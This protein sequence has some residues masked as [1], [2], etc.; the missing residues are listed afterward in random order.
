ML[1]RLAKERGADYVVVGNVGRRGFAGRLTGSVP[2]G[3]K[4]HIP[5]AEVVIVDT[6]GGT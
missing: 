2:E 3:I 1:G 5:D 6:E 4:R